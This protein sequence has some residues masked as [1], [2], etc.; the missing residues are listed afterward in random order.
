MY[1]NQH[2]KLSKQKEETEEYAPNERRRLQKI[3]LNKNRD[4]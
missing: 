2:R 3:K 4:K 1:R